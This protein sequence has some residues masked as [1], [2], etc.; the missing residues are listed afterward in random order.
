LNKIAN[1]FIQYDILNK[2]A[3]HFIQYDILNK[4]EFSFLKER[5]NSNTNNIESNV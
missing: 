5:N 2:I 1:H 3:N 4:I